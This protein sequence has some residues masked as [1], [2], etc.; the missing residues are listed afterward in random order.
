M[1][2]GGVG[3]GRDT[4]QVLTAGEAAAAVA[5]VSAPVAAVA[6]DD[7]A[8]EAPNPRVSAGADVAAADEAPSP[9]A[10]AALA[11]GAADAGAPKPKAG[12]D[13]EAAGAATAP[14]TLSFMHTRPFKH[15]GGDKTVTQLSRKASPS[16]MANQYIKESAANV[17]SRHGEPHLKEALARIMNQQSLQAPHL[18]QAASPK[19]A[20]TW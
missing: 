11:G 12:C 19:W 6:A 4:L 10:G 8:A 18:Q 15:A 1:H 2:V 3:K 5:T 17:C 9:K 7:A 20:Q 14:N 13:A 16:T